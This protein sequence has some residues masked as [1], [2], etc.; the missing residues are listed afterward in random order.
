MRSEPSFQFRIVPSTL[1]DSIESLKRYHYIC[2]PEVYRVKSSIYFS[3]IKKI[4][5]LEIGVLQW[6]ER[7]LIEYFTLLKVCLIFINLFVIFLNLFV[8]LFVYYFVLH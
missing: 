6:N 1:K 2:K 8:C 4:N 3:L 5:M 7:T